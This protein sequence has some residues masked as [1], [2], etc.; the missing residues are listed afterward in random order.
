MAPPTVNGALNVIA[1]PSTTLRLR[2]FYLDDNSHSVIVPT[3]PTPGVGSGTFLYNPTDSARLL[4]NT[5]S[6]TT[7]GVTPTQDVDNSFYVDATFDAGA[8]LG[9]WYVATTYTHEGVTRTQYLTFPLVA[10]GA[11]VIASSTLYCSVND[12]V[13]Y[14]FRNVEE[15]DAN[16]LLSK[17]DLE[18]IIQQEDDIID[19][20][21]NRSWQTMTSTDE[22]QDAVFSD[23]WRWHGDYIMQATTTHRPLRQLTKVE[24]VQGG[25]FVD[26]T[27]VENRTSTYYT[28]RKNGEFF[29]V[30]SQ[31]PSVLRKGIRFTYTWGETAVPGTIKEAAILLVAAYV[32]ES[33]AYAVDLPETSVLGPLDQRIDRWRKRAYDI[34]DR[35][36]SLMYAA[37]GG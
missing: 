23:K 26:I 19:S 31:V 30:G 3:F 28:D 10:A 12:V 17:A 7:S 18:S 36:K 6:T 29:I 33:E 14:L 15:V 4:T 32:M 34:L 2:W 37:S 25:G 20:F 8:A 9:T 13:T 5:A 24:V 11:S 27:A 16:T 22:L 21:V 35:E 1:N